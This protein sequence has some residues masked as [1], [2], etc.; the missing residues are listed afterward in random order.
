[1]KVEKLAFASLACVVVFLLASFA[2]KAVNKNTQTAFFAYG[3]NLGQATMAS[4][5]GGFINATS[6]RLPGYALAFASQDN[7]PAEFGVAT[8]VEGKAGSVSGAL[9]YLTAEQ[10]SSLDGQSGVPGFYER[11]KV[12]V[13]LPDGSLVGADAYFLAGDTHLALP[14]RPYILSATSGLLEWGYGIAELDA[15]IAAAVQQN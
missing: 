14:S 15:A 12:L 6:A 11:R 4:R 2:M 7:R 13:E 5:A 3:A 10:M 1:M 9:Y 8:L